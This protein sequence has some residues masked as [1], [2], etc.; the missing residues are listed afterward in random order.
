MFQENWDELTGVE[1]IETRLNVREMEIIVLSGKH[2]R[3]IKNQQASRKRWWD[4][5]RNYNRE[6]FIARKKE[7]AKEITEIRD[8]LARLRIEFE[9]TRGARSGDTG[10]KNLTC[11]SFELNT[12][13]LAKVEKL[14]K[15]YRG[16][17]VLV[18]LTS[19]E[20]GRIYGRI[21]WARLGSQFADSALGAKPGCEGIC[22]FPGIGIVRY[23]I[24]QIFAVLEQIPQ[25]LIASVNNY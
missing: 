16:F 13:A 15:P 17:C 8:D 20:T 24:Q 6:L 18:K 1:G 19:T 14:E 2:R 11:S 3:L 5:H 21:G 9:K 12:W 7:L 22:H 25:E 23:Q 10:E 4:P